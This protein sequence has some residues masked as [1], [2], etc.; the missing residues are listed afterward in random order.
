MKLSIR[1]F[2]EYSTGALAMLII[3]V[4]VV[5]ALVYAVVHGLATLETLATG[6]LQ[7]VGCAIGGLIGSAL[8]MRF[9]AARTFLRN[10]L[11]DV[12]GDG[13]EPVDS[14]LTGCAS[15]AYIGVHR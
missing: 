11:K 8:V 9:E 6:T 14:W 10:L 13:L 12:L 3:A 15:L 4:S 7:G 2:V 1:K 5:M